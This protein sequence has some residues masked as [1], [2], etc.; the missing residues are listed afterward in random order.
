MRAVVARR[1]DGPEAIELIDTDVPEPAAGQVRIKVAAAAV[2]PVDV[3][4][5]TGLLV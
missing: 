4:V 1:L 2:N 5:S 3:A